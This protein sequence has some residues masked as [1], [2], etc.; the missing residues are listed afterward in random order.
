M[1]GQSRMEL[2][3]QKEMDKGPAFAF[4]KFGHSALRPR[5]ECR[6]IKPAFCAEPSCIT[7]PHWFK[8]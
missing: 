5:P 4:E 3:A 8:A 7:R 6:P 1:K 2:A